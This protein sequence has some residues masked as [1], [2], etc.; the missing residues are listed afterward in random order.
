MCG[1]ARA[2]MAPAAVS[3]AAGVAPARW[4][5]RER[6]TPRYNAAPGAWLPV[7]RTAAPEAPAQAPA[8]VQQQPAEGG[9]AAAAAEA[10]R[11]R[12]LQA[13]GAPR[14]PCC[15]IAP[16]R[17]ARRPR[18][19]SPRERARARALAGSLLTPCPQTMRWGLVPSYTRPDEAPNF[20][21]MFNA[22][23]DT[24]ADKP[25]FSRL[26]GRRRCVVLLNGY[27][28]WKQEGSHGTAV[29]QPY[30]LHA[31]AASGAPEADAPEALLRAA[32]LYDRWQ[33]PEG[34]EPLYTVTI[35]TKDAAPDLRWLHDRMPVFLRSEEEE[36]A[37]LVRG[38]AP[39]ATQRRRRRRV[40]WMCQR[41][42]LRADAP[43]RCV[44]RAGGRRAAEDAEPGGAR[45][46]GA[47]A[48]VAP[49][50]RAHEQG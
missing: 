24:A 45:G 1:R 3:R 49:R 44:F 11:E 31:A 7:V 17:G 43:L 35:L 4:R 16:A 20:Y 32:G 23:A 18:A 2:S 34:S 30:Y 39:R 19:A 33:G 10:P 46:G 6:Y 8:D 37:W 13:R 40:V 29:K 5:D 15:D 9:A 48:G 14:H 50:E 12:V 42:A 21:R 22:R 25:V 28:E 36:R 26:L 41:C 38:A 47:A 27:Y